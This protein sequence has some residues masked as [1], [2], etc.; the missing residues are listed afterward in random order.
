MEESM[1]RKGMAILAGTLVVLLAWANLGLAGSK[2]R[3]RQ[4]VHLLNERVAVLEAQMEDA[5]YITANEVT[6]VATDS[7]PPGSPAIW[8]KIPTTSGDTGRRLAC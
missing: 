2:D 4:K 5:A 6:L 3:L 7:C 8:E 1:R